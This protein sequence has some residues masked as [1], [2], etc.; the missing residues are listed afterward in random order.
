MVPRLGAIIALEIRVTAAIAHV[1]LS[2]MFDH[3][4]IDEIL[5]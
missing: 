1:E 2:Q 4:W 3:C 5:L